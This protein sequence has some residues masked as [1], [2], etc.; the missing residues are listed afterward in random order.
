MSRERSRSTFNPLLRKYKILLAGVVLLLSACREQTAS[1]SSSPAV[2]PRTVEI[3][4]LKDA[5]VPFFEPM[6]REPDDW[7]IGHPE[8]GQT[9]TEYVAGHPTLPTPERKTIYI[10]PIGTF[11]DQQRKA[12]RLTA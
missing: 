8:N 6:H 1:N 10:Q 7:L 12:L 5:V 2:D 9:F 11:T 4:A 3:A